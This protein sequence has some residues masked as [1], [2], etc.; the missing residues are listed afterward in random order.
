M[1]RACEE[2]GAPALV[3]GAAIVL[4]TL[5]GGCGQRGPL[6]LPESAQPVERL[7]P[8]AAPPTTEP[9]AA[10]TSEEPEDED[11]ERSENER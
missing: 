3:R 7:D 2:R 4:L 8:A 9:S 11:A 5:L 6:T 1:R 10:E